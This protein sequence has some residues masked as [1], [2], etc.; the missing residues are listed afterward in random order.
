[1]YVRARVCKM[2][3]DGTRNVNDTK[4][5]CNDDKVS[6]GRKE[7][8]YTDQK[9]Q[10][11]LAAYRT[12]WERGEPAVASVPSR[13]AEA[14]LF[15]PVPDTSISANA[16]FDGPLYETSILLYFRVRYKS[17]FFM[18][19][20]YG[21]VV[22]G[23][24]FHPGDPDSKNVF[25]YLHRD[26]EAPESVYAVRE[27]C[28]WCTYN[29][30]HEAI[31]RDRRFNILTTNCQQIVHCDSTE[32]ALIGLG[33]IGFF[34]LGLFHSSGIYLVLAGIFFILLSLV[35]TSMVGRKK[36]TWCKH[37]RW[38]GGQSW[39]TIDD[40]NDDNDDDDDDDDNNNGDNDTKS[41]I[42]DDRN[43]NQE[44]KNDLDKDGNE[45]WTKRQS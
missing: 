18:P 5:K 23:R 43:K 2:S 7:E 39:P 34:A 21:L 26:F 17:L 15:E 22:D 45:P 11:E 24:W 12:R 42:E 20:H 8:R 19:Y 25:G 10:R 33:M 38:A 35:Y 29:L 44:E 30:L 3:I 4:V 6:H 27:L 16:P 37:I 1:M 40:D 31:E 41:D 13:L 9:I 28:G 36:P 14:G 32:S